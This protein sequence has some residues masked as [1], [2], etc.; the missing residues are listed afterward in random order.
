[1]KATIIFSDIDFEG[2]PVDIRVLHNRESLIQECEQSLKRLGVETIDLYQVH[3]PGKNSD[4]GGM[5]ETLLHL[6]QQGK[7]RAIGVSN[8]STAQIE[9]CLQ[10]GQLDCEQPR[11]NLLCAISKMIFC[12]F[13]ASAKWASSSI[14]RWSSAC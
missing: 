13:A 12:R 1:M 3:W 14:A 4:F 9:N 5:M 11:Y 6:K 8:F 2:N 10:Y 7:I